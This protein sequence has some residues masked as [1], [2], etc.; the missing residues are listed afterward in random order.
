M[1]REAVQMSRNDMYC[2]RYSGLGVFGCVDVHPDVFEILPVG[3]SHPLNPP[4]K[5]VDDEWRDIQ[6]AEALALLGEDP[7]GNPEDDLSVLEQDHPDR[8]ARV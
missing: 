4:G 2:V 8:P 1:E 6:A 5:R 7:L 3:V